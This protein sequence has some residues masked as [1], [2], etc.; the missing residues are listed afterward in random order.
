MQT[1]SVVWNENIILVF[2]ESQ[3]GLTV[4]SEK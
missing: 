1:L 4:K 3:V 2:V